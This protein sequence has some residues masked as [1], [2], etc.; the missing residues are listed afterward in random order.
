MLS[1]EQHEKYTDKDFLHDLFPCG[2]ITFQLDGTIISVNQTLADWTGKS[3]SA[4]IGANFKSLLEQASK[5]YYDLF[6]APQLVIHGIANEYSLR[7]HSEKQNYDALFN[8]RSY[9][10]ESGHSLF[11]VASIQKIMSRKKYETELLLEKRNAVDQ[12]QMAMSEKRRFE[13]L[14]SSFPNNFW[15][16]SAMGHLSNMNSKAAKHFSSLP[17]TYLGIFGAVYQPDRSKALR[18]WRKSLNQGKPF[19]KELRLLDPHGRPEWHVVTAEPYYN[20]ED[21]IEMWFCNTTNI[22]HQKLLQLA[23]QHELKSHLSSAYQHLDQKDG[24]LLEI[25]ADQSHMVRK[26]LANIIGLIALLQLDKEAVDPQ[27]LQLISHSAAELDEMI[28]IISAKTTLT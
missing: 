3:I 4:L 15:T 8:A 5:I 26:P 12:A 19:K 27:V 18:S 25:A 14:F 2:L 20:D 7:F 23:N 9:S 6:I 13:F 24:L 17:S 16:I 22:H 10:E 28:R 21:K 1:P 11:V